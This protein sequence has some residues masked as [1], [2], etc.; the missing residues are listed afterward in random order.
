MSFLEPTPDSIEIN[1][2]ILST[3]ILATYLLAL[4]SGR[5]FTHYISLRGMTFE[6]SLN[7]YPLNTF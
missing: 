2:R 4:Q 7:E 6:Y 3:V 5:V 1:L